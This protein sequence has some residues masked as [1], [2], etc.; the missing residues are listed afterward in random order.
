[1]FFT[2]LLSCWS[3]EW[4]VSVS[5]LNSSTWVLGE[6]NKTQSISAVLTFSAKDNRS[7]MNEI[8][9]SN[10]GYCCAGNAM[11][12]SHWCVKKCG[13]HLW[14]TLISWLSAC[15]SETWTRDSKLK[16]QCAL[17]AFPPIYNRRCNKDSGLFKMQHIKSAV[18]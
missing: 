9:M 13:M 7:N 2:C 3:S 18:M 5:F 10:P 12:L 17:D 8:L 14:V 16:M 11:V 1:M 4:R 15:T 6:G